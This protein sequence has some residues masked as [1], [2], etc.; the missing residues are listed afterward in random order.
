MIADTGKSVTISGFSSQVGDI[1][2]VPVASCATLYTCPVTS[3][4]YTLVCHQSLYFGDRLDGNPSL[5]NP[6]QLRLN[7]ID[8]FDIPKQF[9]SHSPHAI[10]AGDLT[11]PLDLQGVCSGFESRKPTDRELDECPRIDLTSDL[12][13]EPNSDFLARREADAI[14]RTRV[15]S[16]SAQEAEMDECLTPIR[17]QFG[18]RTRQRRPRM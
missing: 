5:L 12:E 4:K 17:T 18:Y 7:G 14:T 13:W 3:V 10:V 2:S 16:A 1:K 8:V 9:D 15:V 6:N 11:I